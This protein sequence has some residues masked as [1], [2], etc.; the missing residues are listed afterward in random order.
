MNILITGISG[1]IG[2]ALLEE[3]KGSTHQLFCVSRKPISFS[4]P[5]IHSIIADLSTPGFEKQL[6]S[7]IDCIVHMAQ[8]QAYREFPE[9]AADIFQVNVNATFTLLNWA[10]RQNVS[11]FIHFSSGNVYKPQDKLLTEFDA[12]ESFSFYGTTKIMGEQLCEQFSEYFDLTILRPFS[13]YGPKQEG[14]LM[15]N[16]YN[17]INKG[18]SI[19]LAGGVGLKITPLF[20]DDCI[21]ALVKILDRPAKKGLKIY[22][23]SGNEVVSIRQIA[24]EIGKVIKRQIN[25]QEE[26]GTPLFLMGDNK[27]IKEDLNLKLSV[28]LSDGLKKVFI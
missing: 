20:I 6:P 11:R 10:Y 16:I 18:Q 9:K 24:E 2:T 3:L 4:A 13:I 7:G 15:H 17:R 26:V 23:L 5:N 28:R 21:E 1:F 14:M 8:S 19:T 27:K 12:R 25:Y 22:N